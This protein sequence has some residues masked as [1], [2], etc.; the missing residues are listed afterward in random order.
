MQ[1]KIVRLKKL[2]DKDTLKDLL[3][4]FVYYNLS[5]PTGQKDVCTIRL[6]DNVSTILTPDTIYKLD[7][8]LYA[9]LYILANKVTANLYKIAE[10]DTVL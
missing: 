1:K 2:S 7:D 5:Y 6:L 9:H 4:L 10:D 8:E 3:E